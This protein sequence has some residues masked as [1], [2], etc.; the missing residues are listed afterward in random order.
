MVR[1]HYIL[2]LAISLIYYVFLGASGHGV[3]FK[4]ADQLVFLAEIFCYFFL[5]IAFLVTRKNTMETFNWITTSLLVFT[6]F[7]T[8]Y[9]LYANSRAGGP[10]I[11]QIL[12]L[13]IALIDTILLV[14]QLSAERKPV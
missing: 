5:G 13:V 2:L 10:L 12:I 6:E 3:N 4:D 8:L 7:F 14:I 11:I 1:V 9:S